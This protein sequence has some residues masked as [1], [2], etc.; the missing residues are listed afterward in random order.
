MSTVSEEF[1]F[2]SLELIEVPFRHAGVDYVLREAT[3]EAARQYR[4]AVIACTQFNSDGKPMSIKNV[5]NVEPLLVHLC[6]FQAGKMGAQVSLDKVKSWPARMV[7]RLFDKA[8]EI[9][10]LDEVS[11]SLDSLRKKREEI[12]QKILQMEK[13]EESLGNSAD[14]TGLGIE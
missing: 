1:N 10:H 3:G 7:K 5:A 8:K 12:D 9:S 4:N 14:S 11:E 13:A 6:S 2:D